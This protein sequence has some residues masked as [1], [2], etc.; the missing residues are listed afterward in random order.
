MKS[1]YCDG[2]SL[3]RGGGKMI[4]SRMMQ[5]VVL[6]LWCWFWNSLALVHMNVEVL[7]TR[8]L[9]KTRII[10]VWNLIAALIWYYVYEEFLVC[11]V[12]M[13]ID[14]TIRIVAICTMNLSTWVSAMVYMFR[15]KLILK[16]FFFVNIAP[17]TRNLL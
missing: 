11:I 6:S 5:K 15:L 14:N 17:T 1:R 12:N 9:K 13:I 16:Y 8:S 10:N 2:W 7:Q 3:V 4:L